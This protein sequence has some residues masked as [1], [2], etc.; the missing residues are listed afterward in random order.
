MVVGEE[1]VVK[2]RGETLN[3]GIIFVYKLGLFDLFIGQSV[4]S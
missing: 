2:K 1:L 3:L 4:F